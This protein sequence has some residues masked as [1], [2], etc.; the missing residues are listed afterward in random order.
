MSLEA[1]S[2]PVP[3]GG[4]GHEGGSFGPVDGRVAGPQ[5]DVLDEPGLWSPQRRGLTVALVLTI[6]L[7]A[8]EALAIATVMP[9]VK[10]DLGGLGLYGWV[11]SGF[12]LSSLLGIVVAGQ[13]ADRK[14]LALPFTI[15][16]GLFAAGLAV[17]GAATSMSMLVGARV[18][19][20]FGAGTI[21]SVGYAAIGR[22]YPASLR[23]R[24]FATTST[25]WVV[26]GLIGPAVA[27]FVD[28]ALSWRWV[29]LGLLPIV[30]VA[31][32][33]GIPALRALGIPGDELAETGTEAELAA[34]DAHDRRTVRRAVLLVVALAAVFGAGVGVP[35][36]VAVAFVVAGLPL[37]VWAFVGLVPKGTVSLVPG[38]PATVGIRGLLTWAFFAADAYIPLAVVDGRH[39]ATWIAAA[40]L[41]VG[42]VSWAS[43]S[44]VQARLIDRLGPRR[45]D[46]YG[47]TSIIVG[48]SLMIGVSQGLPVGLAVLAWAIGCFGIGLAY[49]AL[50]VTV[51]ASAAPGEEGSASAAL[52]L[53]DALGVAVGTGISGWIVAVFD[54]A[55]RSVAASTTV[56][57]VVALAIGIAGLVGTAR[58]P[59]RVPDQVT[60]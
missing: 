25:A 23:P 56:V 55:G 40:A 42:S 33:M 54:H 27:T 3:P 5:R 26:P 17:G 41:S 19:Q 49:S 43:A 29:F 1:A 7:V 21:P 57:F 16:L 51:L 47:F 30:A 60:A 50:S 38:V 24:M 28:Q 15:G 6:T 31:A 48:V 58:L 34:R 39:A 2:D 52:Q 8:F 18:A 45:L 22:G 11:F 12:F 36:A 53:S 46:R 13:L 20:G 14:G 32:V 44:W 35:V 59:A 10:D 4:A 9:A 37:A